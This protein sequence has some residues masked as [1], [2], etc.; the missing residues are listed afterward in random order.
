MADPAN[1]L[2]ATVL[3]SVLDQLTLAIFVFRGERLIYTNPRATR[4]INRLRT[5]YRI[6]LLVMLLEIHSRTFDV[7]LFPAV[8]GLGRPPVPA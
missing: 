3:R 6:E 5:K 7:Q 4:L 2:S 8:L 1:P